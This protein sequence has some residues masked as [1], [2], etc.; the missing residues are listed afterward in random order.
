M[1]NAFESFLWGIIA[2]FGALIVEIIVFLGIS[3]YKNIEFSFDIFFAVP[4]FILISAC[5]EEFFKYMIISKKVESFSLEKSYIVN[6]ILVGLGFFAV[7]L[8]LIYIS[9]EILPAW[10]I[11]AEIAILHMG[12]AGLIGY[13]IAI[14]NPRKFFT[15]LL[16]LSVAVAFHAVY[17]FLVIKREFLQNYAVFCLLGVLIL[18]NIVNFFRVS[19]KINPDSK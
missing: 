14:K 7:E 3:V 15:F 11:L 5:I 16:A 2:A 8:G 17:N 9:N 18:I 10:N 12:T 4:L 13:I 1:K 6:S 19:G